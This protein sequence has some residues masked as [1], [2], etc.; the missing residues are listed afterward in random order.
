MHAYKHNTLFVDAR[1]QPQARMDQGGLK[2]YCRISEHSSPN[3][4]YTRPLPKM[5]RSE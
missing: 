5:G 4:R 2:A 1:I 3:S